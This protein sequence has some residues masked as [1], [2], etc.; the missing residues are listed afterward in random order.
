MIIT[1]IQMKRLNEMIMVLER[2]QFQRAVSLHIRAGVSRIK[3]I[4]ISLEKIYRIM[5]DTLDNGLVVRWKQVLDLRAEVFLLMDETS[6]LEL[7]INMEPILG[8]PV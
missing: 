6:H 3:N 7:K 2:R 1:E 8:K 5:K 4:Y